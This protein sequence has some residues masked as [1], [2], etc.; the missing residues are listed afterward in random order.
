VLPSE[1]DGWS[2]VRGWPGRAQ[3]DVAVWDTASHARTCMIPREVWY[4]SGFL[5]LQKTHMLHRSK[6]F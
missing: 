1:G 4:Y 3:I 2:D 5:L 6:T